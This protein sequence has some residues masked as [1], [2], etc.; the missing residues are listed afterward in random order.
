MI[1]QFVFQLQECGSYT[2]QWVSFTGYCV[3]LTI[4]E[5]I[6]YDKLKLNAIA[7][8]VPCHDLYVCS[9]DLD[10]FQFT[11]SVLP[12]PECSLATSGYTCLTFVSC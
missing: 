9:H 7:E 4:C 2:V 1:S 6:I 11:D 12:K 5:N 10:Y 8:A 3:S